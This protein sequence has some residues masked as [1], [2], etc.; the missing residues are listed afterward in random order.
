MV[1]LTALKWKDKGHRDSY[2]SVNKQM[3]GVQDVK[4]SGHEDKVLLQTYGNSESGDHVKS[5][6]I[7]KSSG[8]N[9]VQAV[10]GLLESICVNREGI[11]EI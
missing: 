11:Q 2:P 6:E 4:V 1:L 9:H 7:S 5:D 10:R 8:D 3:L